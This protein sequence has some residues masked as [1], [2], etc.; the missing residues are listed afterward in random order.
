[1]RR[2]TPS[3]LLA[4]ALAVAVALAAAGCASRHVVSRSGGSARAAGSPGAAEGTP[5]AA[6]VRPAFEATDAE[7]AAARDLLADGGE[8]TSRTLARFV[9]S[10]AG[11]LRA[12]YDA[13]LVR[14]PVLRGKVVLRFT[15]RPDGTVGEVAPVYDNL[16]GGVARPCL[17]DR[18]AAWR[19][20]FRPAEPVV[21]EY[22]LAFTPAR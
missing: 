7:V 11:E 12:C 20:P 2:P 14:Y 13:A 15:I 21:V 19:T 4:S 22:P 17:V 9:F 18:V 16:G 6:P 5:P 8:P 3:A 10:R 1:M